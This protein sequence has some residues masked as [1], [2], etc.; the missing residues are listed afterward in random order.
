MFP[1]LFKIGSFEIRVYSLMLVIAILVAIWL[2]GRRSK[3]LGYDQKIIEN[4]V[5]L[6]FIGGI[7]GARLYYVAFN[8]GYFGKNPSEIIAVWHGGLAIHGGIIAGTLTALT[9]CYYKKISIF[10]YMDLIA[11]C[12][13]LGQGIGRFGNFANGEA[14]GV[15]TITPP[16][17]I[18]SV[19]PHFTEF[20]D[21]V[22]IT[23]KITN[24]PAA[25]TGLY[26]KIISSTVIV[27]FQGKDLL[28]KEYVPWGIS[29]PSTY[30][31]PAYREFGSM[32]VH[33]TFFYEM[34][35]NFIGAAILFWLWKKDKNIGTGKLAAI[36]FLMYACIRAFV[37]FFRA[38]D[39]MLGPIRAPHAASLG[40]IALAVVWYLVAGYF[41]RRKT[42]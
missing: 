23:E 34:I 39:L 31:P 11:P 18:F 13:L 25:I 3:E 4:I 21:T 9:Y 20:W 42:A 35:L 27:N 29:F 14:H 40:L 7:I 36:Y 15:P 26:Q 24:A 17:I 30:M 6:T 22:L 5:I 37:T 38:D 10:A 2:I 19:K 8:W 41:N 12:L 16:S 1:Y 32:P 28:L 33:P